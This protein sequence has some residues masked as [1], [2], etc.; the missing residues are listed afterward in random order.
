MNLPG[1]ASKLVSLYASHASNQF[2]LYGNVNDRFVLPLG[3]KRALGSL[4]E[5]LAKVMMPRRRK[6]RTRDSRR[7]RRKYSKSVSTAVT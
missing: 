1:W 4:Y 6:C 3:E 2:L 5:F 7:L